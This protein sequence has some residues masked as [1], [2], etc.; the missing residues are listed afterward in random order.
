MNALFCSTLTPLITWAEWIIHSIY[1][2]WQTEL[3]FLLLDMN[4]WN[5]LPVAMNRLQFLH[6]YLSAKMQWCFLFPLP[7]HI[8]SV[9]WSWPDL[10]T[11]FSGHRNHQ[12]GVLRCTGVQPQVRSAHTCYYL[13]LFNP[14]FVLIYILKI[15]DEEVCVFL[16]Y[17]I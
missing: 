13:P 3:L 9:D 10:W 8:I 11:V 7:Q 5:H 16:V 2:P 17:S 14:F 1:L 12:G 4:L 6:V 15:Y